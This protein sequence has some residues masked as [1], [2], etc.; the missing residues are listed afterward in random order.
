MSL[1]VKA[2]QTASYLN[3]LLAEG[4]DLGVDVELPATEQE[5]CPL[6]LTQ[7]KYNG[8]LV[9][10]HYCNYEC[11]VPLRVFAVR[12]TI[13]KECRIELPWDRYTCELT[14]MP[15]YRGDYYVGHTSFPASQVLNERFAT[16]PF[17]IRGGSKLEGILLAAGCERVPQKQRKGLVAVKITLV[18]IE[19]RE[20]R[21]EITIAA[22]MLTPAYKGKTRTERASEAKEQLRGGKPLEIRFAA[23]RPFD[24]KPAMDS[25]AAPAN[26]DISSPSNLS[27]PKEGESESA[28]SASYSQV[29]ANRWLAGQE[30]CRSDSDQSFGAEEGS[31]RFDASAATWD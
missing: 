13:I 26:C 23:L 20:V 17:V 29:L 31:S 6:Q 3:Q 12:R 9:A 22:R 25:S 10:R 18:D 19:D 4:V 28:D 7:G 1:S 16:P 8:I 11:S 15:K 27:N 21:T 30:Q 5:A 14:D 24:Q 2:R